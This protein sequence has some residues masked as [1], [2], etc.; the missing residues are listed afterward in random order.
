MKARRVGARITANLGFINFTGSLLETQL[1]PLQFEFPRWT[2]SCPAIYTFGMGLVEEIVDRFWP[3][4]RARQRLYLS[5]FSALYLTHSLLD[6]YH[7]CTAT[8]VASQMGL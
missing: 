3:L 7:A 5:A 2:I 8:A 6:R 1:E 4:R